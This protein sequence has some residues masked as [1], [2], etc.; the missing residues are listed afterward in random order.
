MIS[1][2]VAMDEN[3][4]I[5]NQNQLPWS[6]PA[7]LAYFKKI[8]TGHPIIMGRKTYESIGRPL[9][10][11]RNIVITSND[12]FQVD[13]VEVVHSIEDA[14]KLVRDVEAFIIGGATIFEQAF[15][16]AQKLYI[17][18][19]HE[20]FK[21]D[22]YFNNFSIDDWL[23]VSSEKGLKNEKNPYDYDFVVY[24]RK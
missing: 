21:G 22:T 17:T 2:I 11:R 24:N 9:P 14:I 8:T 23:L 15:E 5:G 13:G 4:V 12:T 3:G 16:Y 19:I 7:D 6:L 10:G 1:F 20:S 18:H